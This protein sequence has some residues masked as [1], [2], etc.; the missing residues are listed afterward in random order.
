MELNG[1][2]SSEGTLNVPTYIIGSLPPYHRLG[3]HPFFPFHS[4]VAIKIYR[5]QQKMEQ[6]TRRFRDLNLLSNLDLNPN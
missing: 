4:I 2:L 3:I 1:D 6:Q 5:K